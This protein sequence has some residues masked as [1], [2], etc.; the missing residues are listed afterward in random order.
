M[1]VVASAPREIVMHSHGPSRGAG[2]PDDFV[3]AAGLDWLLPLYDPLCRLLGTHR[4]RERLLDQ[5]DVRP[6]DRVLDLGCGTGALS[7]QLV[8]RAPGGS[9]P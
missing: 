1:I 8:R 3:P 9:R 7:L 4:H 5:A 2:R 6:G